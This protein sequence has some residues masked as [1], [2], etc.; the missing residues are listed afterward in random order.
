VSDASDSAAA[1]ALE[2]FAEAF[3]VA[4]AA[5]VRWMDR[6]AVYGENREGTM[7]TADPPAPAPQQ[8]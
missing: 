1:T 7:L 3:T 4:A 5:C 2:T 8:S 6:T